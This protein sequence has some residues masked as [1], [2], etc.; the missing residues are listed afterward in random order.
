MN[1][2]SESSSIT[3]HQLPLTDFKP[4]RWHSPTTSL[5][6][7]T[8][9][10]HTHAELDPAIACFE[11]DLGGTYSTTENAAGATSIQAI[12][13]CNC[14][15]RFVNS[16]DQAACHLLTPLRRPSDRAHYKLKFEAQNFHLS[17]SLF[18]QPPLFRAS[19]R[20]QFFKSFEFCWCSVLGVPSFLLYILLQLH[21]FLFP[22]STSLPGGVPPLVST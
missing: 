14:P 10:K 19:V 17:S 22:L 3:H 4:P 18:N 13:P 11:A 1:I 9:I 21:F 6:P 2:P 12:V 7:D 15:I 20:L 8:D 16:L 5:R